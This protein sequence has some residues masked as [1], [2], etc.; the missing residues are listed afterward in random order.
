MGLPNSIVDVIKSIQDGEIGLIDVIKIGDLTV[1]QLTGLSA[2]KSLTP[3]RKPV[4]AGFAMTDAAVDD[5]IE[6]TPDILL[7]NPDFSIESGATAVLSGNVDSLTKTW[8]DDKRE[9]YQKF[10]DREILTIQTHEDVYTSMLLQSIDP[11]YDV[12]DNSNAFIATVNA[13]Q[14]TQVEDESTGG[15]IDGIEEVF[16]EL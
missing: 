7:A 11:L 1:S 10:D 4:Q 16:G 14:I 2:P 6:L 15:T 9:L 8:R 12:S 3:T 5:P 13:I